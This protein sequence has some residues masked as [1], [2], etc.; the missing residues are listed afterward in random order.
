MV[1]ANSCFD[2]KSHRLKDLPRLYNE[3]GNMGMSQRDL[4]LF[5]ESG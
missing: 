5:V 3:K 4:S 2:N 1:L